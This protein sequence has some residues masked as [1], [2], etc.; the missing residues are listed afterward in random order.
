MTLGQLLA[1]E[2]PARIQ[3]QQDPGALERADVGFAPLRIDRQTL[4]VDV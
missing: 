2:E 4:V 1:G 3:I